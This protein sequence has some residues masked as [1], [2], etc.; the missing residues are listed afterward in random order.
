MRRSSEKIV[1]HLTAKYAV[2]LGLLAVLAVVNYFILRRTVE[3]NSRL[4]KIVDQA[5][6]Q[7]MLLLKTAIHSERLVFSFDELAR[8]QARQEL[9]TDARELEQTHEMLM[10]VSTEEEVKVA[11]DVRSVYEDL[12]WQ[13]DSE[14]RQYLLHVYALV[15]TKDEQ[16]AYDDVNFAY[17]RNP[18]TIERIRKG[19]EAVVDRY[20]QRRE[21][22]SRHLG[23]LALWTIASTLLLLLFNGWFIFR[24]MV[25]RVRSDV[26]ALDSLNETLEDRVLQ[27]TNE[28][29]TRARRLAESEAALIE[30]QSLYLSLVDHLPMSVIRK[31]R[32][33]R[34]TFANHRFCELMGM[35]LE[36]I[37]GCTDI[38]LYPRE[39]ALKYRN[40]DLAVMESGAVF[41]DVE[42]HQ[43]RGG[44][45]LFVEVLKVPL[46]DS[47]NQIIGTQ[48]MFWDVTDRKLAEE[49]ALQTERLAAIGQMVAG[50]AHESRNALQQIQACSQLLLWE[51]DGDEKLRD[52]VKDLQAAEERLLRTFEELRSYAAPMKLDFKPCDIRSIV[53]SAWA[54]TKLLRH[55][56]DIS[57]A[58]HEGNPVKR[59]MADPIRLEQVFRNLFENS[60]SATE[61][62]VRIEVRYETLSDDRLQV[63]VSDNGPGLS[64]EQQNRIFD[65]FFTTKTQGTGLGMAIV[66][67]TIR[68]H[69]GDITAESSSAGAILIVT[70]PRGKLPTAIPVDLDPREV[71]NR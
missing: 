15:N 23:V 43:A 25:Y 61:D 32:V 49:R 27:R 34:V 40:D 4:A 5:S 50:V 21:A 8:L 52:L 20:E 12:P 38:E 19:L 14:M 66:K 69:G 44:R 56:R 68:A 33:G 58:E 47:D 65:P 3:E 39:L 7:R 18:D 17:I 64:P 31:D 24:P 26:S 59:C 55:G 29:E 67:R 10:P 28:A 37:T 9:L 2:A 1:R 53:K 54:T 36:H 6:R 60:I 45:N 35:S 16:L 71:R 30:S 57:L 11:E 62:P 22:E 70:L 41:Q 13:L 42:E 48:T 46:R 51:L 63:T